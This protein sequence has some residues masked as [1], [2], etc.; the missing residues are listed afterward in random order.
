[1]D[2][3]YR[4]HYLAMMGYDLP[5]NLS[6]VTVSGRERKEEQLTGEWEEEGGM[7][8]SGE[9]ESTPEDGKGCMGTCIV[10]GSWQSYS[11]ILGNSASFC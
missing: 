11:A 6:L 5:E 1:M 4:Y 3:N 10:H 9:M 8:S 7:S 2:K